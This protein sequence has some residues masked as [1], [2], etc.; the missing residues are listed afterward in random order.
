MASVPAHNR[1]WQRQPRAR[2]EEKK[3]VKNGFHLAPNIVGRV[4]SWMCLGR[5]FRFAFDIQSVFVILCV[6]GP[7]PT[8]QAVGQPS[9]SANSFCGL[10][11]MKKYA[12]CMAFCIRPSGIYQVLSVVCQKHYLPQP[13]QFGFVQFSI[14]TRLVV[15]AQPSQSSFSIFI[16]ISIVLCVCVCVLCYFSFFSSII[17]VATCFFRQYYFFYMIMESIL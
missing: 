8:S 17:V 2:E 14:Y 16:F 12:K 4:Y 9:G 6:N 7:Q 1:K 11:L 13:W 15:M 3:S 5:S 10:F